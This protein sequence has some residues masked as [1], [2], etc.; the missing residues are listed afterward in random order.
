MTLE[1]GL[2]WIDSCSQPRQLCMER[3][4]LRV[5][6]A[7]SPPGRRRRDSS[8]SSLRKKADYPRAGRSRQLPGRALAVGIT[9]CRKRA[10]VAARALF[11]PRP[12]T[13]Q[14][15]AC[16]HADEPR[17]PTADCASVHASSRTRQSPS[18]GVLVEAVDACGGVQLLA[19][20]GVISL[21][22]TEEPIIRPPGACCHL[23][24]L[25]FDLSCG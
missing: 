12:R 1:E 24:R 15:R 8:G 3:K 4:I 14:I 23:L 21:L 16:S 13:G 9:P 10:P 2:R 20:V 25:L 7:L 6:M 18:A 5:A 17:E 11:A 22:R 19:V